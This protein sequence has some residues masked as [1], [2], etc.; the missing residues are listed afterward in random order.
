HFYVAADEL[1]SSLDGTAMRMDVNRSD[2][3]LCVDQ[4]QKAGFGLLLRV[5]ADAAWASIRAVDHQCVTLHDVLGLEG[6]VKITGVPKAHSIRRLNED[7]NRAEHVPAWDQSYP[8]RPDLKRGLWRERI[9]IVPHKEI[10]IKLRNQQL[11]RFFAHQQ[12]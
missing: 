5:F 7:L 9:K 12:V 10:G 1:Q 8:A 3:Q 4:F 2:L 11:Q 6:P